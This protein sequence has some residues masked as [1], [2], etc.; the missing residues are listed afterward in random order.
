MHS[1]AA[2]LKLHDNL[3]FKHPECLRVIVSILKSDHDNKVNILY[4]VIQNTNSNELATMLWIWV[5]KAA[6]LSSTQCNA[7]DF[8]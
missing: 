7:T 3:P 8:E 5:K 6:S 2:A 4:T 1:D